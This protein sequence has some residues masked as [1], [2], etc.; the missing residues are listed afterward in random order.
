[1]SG[2][3]DRVQDTSAT[4]G[5]GDLTLAGTPPTGFIAFS[6]VFAVGALVYYTITNGTDWEVGRCPLSGSTTLQRSAGR[7]YASSNSGSLVSFT[8]TLTV[9]GD[10]PATFLNRVDSRGR[11]YAMSHGWALP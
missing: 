11:A 10:L 4:T 9:F 1:M 8:G 2:F 3:A 7:V 5:T 6:T